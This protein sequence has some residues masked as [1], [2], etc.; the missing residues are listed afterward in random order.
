MPP[1]IRYS[2]KNPRLNKYSLIQ[3]FA[4][5]FVGSKESNKSSNKQSNSSSEHGSNQKSSHMHP[6]VSVSGHL[7]RPWQNHEFGRQSTEDEPVQDQPVHYVRQEHDPKRAQE[8]EHK[9]LVGGFDS[10]CSGNREA[11]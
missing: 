4:K 10:L 11:H 5:R 1:R 2:N 8:D 3:M 7:F 6:I 9:A